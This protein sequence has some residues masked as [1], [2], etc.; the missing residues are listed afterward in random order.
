VAE[1]RRAVVVVDVERISRSCGYGVP[2]M[3]V[4]GERPH[5][6][7]SKRKR[8]ATMGPEAF[9]T[10]QATRNATSLDGLPAVPLPDSG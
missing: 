4:V 1:A 5:F 10:F 6:D 3:D 8:L 9:G 7:L 2:L